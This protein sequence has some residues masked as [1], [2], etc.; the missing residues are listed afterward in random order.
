MSP[1]RRRRGAGAPPRPAAR[2]R[3]TGPPIPTIVSRPPA[4]PDRS[5]SQVAR[6][7][8]GEAR[9]HDHEEPQRRRRA[10]GPSACGRIPHAA[11]WVD[12]QRPHGAEPRVGRPEEPEEQRDPPA[13]LLGGVAHEVGQHALQAE[14]VAELVR[15]AV[16]RRRDAAQQAHEQQGERQQPEEEAVG[17]RTRQQAAEVAPVALVDVERPARPRA[18]AR[19]RPRRTRGRARTPAAPAPRPRSAVPCAPRSPR[20]RRT[21]L[22]SAV[23]RGRRSPRRPRRRRPARAAGGRATSGGSARSAARPRRAGSGRCR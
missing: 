17:Q 10:V 2:S 3:S 7:R 13:L 6:A 15:G 14:V 8:G 11:A 19:A 20:H 21:A 1:P 12:A 18:S 16:L 23:A 4:T 9:H 22:V 5:R